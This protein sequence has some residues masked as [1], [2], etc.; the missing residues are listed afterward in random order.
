VLLR[1]KKILT[2]WRRPTRLLPITD[3]KRISST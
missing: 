3:G 1:K 2:R